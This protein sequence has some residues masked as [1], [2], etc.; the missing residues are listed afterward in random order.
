MRE[1]NFLLDIIVMY[2]VENWSECS[3]LQINSDL[4]C[5]LVA[6]SISSSMFLHG[7]VHLNLAMCSSCVA[8]VIPRLLMQWILGV[9]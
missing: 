3:L 7:N 4:V 2:E 9:L 8:L 5:L 1:E 6:D